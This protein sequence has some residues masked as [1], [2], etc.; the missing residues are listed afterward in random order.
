MR[1]LRQVRCLPLLSLYKRE[2]KFKLL[3]C[4]NKSLCR[5]VAVRL[6]SGIAF[7]S[8]CILAASLKGA[9]AAASLSAQIAL[10]LCVLPVVV[11]RPLRKPLEMLLCSLLPYDKLC[12]Q[13]L[14]LEFVIIAGNS[15]CERNWTLQE[16]EDCK[17]SSPPASMQVWLVAV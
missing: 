11:L 15:S 3:W 4:H 13:P 16:Q 9:D 5:Q 6:P 17:V 12:L 2:E 1:M 14:T 10:H 7:A 8:T